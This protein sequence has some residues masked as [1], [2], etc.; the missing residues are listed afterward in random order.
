MD[1][2]ATPAALLFPRFGFEAETR[3]VPPA[4]AFVRMTQASANYAALGE[5]GFRALTGLIADVPSVAIDYPDG[6]SA[7]EQVEAL[8]SSL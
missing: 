4:E 7:I 3:P 1:M 5:G 8:C 2:P 6:A